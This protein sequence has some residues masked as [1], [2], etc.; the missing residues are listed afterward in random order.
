MHD[1]TSIFRKT[2]QQYGDRVALIT[3]TG[4]VTFAELE[5]RSAAFAATCTAK[6]IRR[7]D[8]VIV[9]MP[10]GIDLFVALAGAWRL[11]AVVV[12]PEPAMGLKGFR[13]ALRTTR[14]SAFFASGGYR[15]LKLLL[16]SLW[17]ARL[18]TP[19]KGD[20][21]ASVP[22]DL[23]SD[24][25]ALISFTSGSTGAPKAILRSHGFLMA[26]RGAV[27]P[28]L[29]SHRDEVDLVAFPVF[30]L[31]NL[32]AG[33]TSALPNWRL[34][35]PDQLSAPRLAHWIKET[36]ATRALL[37]PALCETLAQADI[38]PG[39][40]T[41]FTGGGPVFPDVVAA[42]KKQRPGL[43]VVSVY[44]STEAEP[45]AE[46]D[47]ADID[48]AL[49]SRMAQGGGLLAGAPVEAAR[50]RI[51]DDEIQVAGAHVND[52]YLD[53]AMNSDTKVR[54]GD[55][56][57]HRTGDAGYLDDAGQLWL[58]GR[59]SA[60]AP[61]NGGKLFP[62]SVEVAARNWPGVDKAAL[63]AGDA[64]TTLVIEGADA[65]LDQCKSNAAAMGVDTV[66]K[67]AKLPM[68]RR[69]QSKVDYNALNALI[70]KSR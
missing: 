3:P 29:A 40:H 22:A 25:P 27:S 44:G 35:R 33:R 70:R 19:R 14:P 20:K 49:L 15:W 45:I 21:G 47:W 24:D 51:V 30:T 63:W 11:G 38:P 55:V 69:H 2:A 52:G 59:H 32:A 23:S 7:G 54:D 4:S 61:T 42:L 16:P 31:L 37:P 36:R 28:L 12:F 34:T 18:C 50:L 26:Q 48:D 62:F 53:P 10:V 17:R 6:G 67:V 9:A 1:L 60:S 39:L 43:R 58:L 41:V 13:H 66:L 8:R 57:W 68:D 65:D 56:I 64:Q 5:S 46:L